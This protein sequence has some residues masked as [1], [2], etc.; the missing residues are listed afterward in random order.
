[1]FQ[2]NT[3]SDMTID[4][5]NCYALW[6]KAL[7]RLSVERALDEHFYDMTGSL[8]NRTQNEQG[9]SDHHNFP[10]MLVRKRWAS[11]PKLDRIFKT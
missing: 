11:D 3:D 5:L 7:H 4:T 8:E 6:T 9:V 2:A 10:G 1:M